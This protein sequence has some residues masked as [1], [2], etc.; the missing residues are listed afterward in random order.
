MIVTEIIVKALSHFPVSLLIIQTPSPGPRTLLWKVWPGDPQKKLA[1]FPLLPFPRRSS[2]SLART[3]WLCFLLLRFFAFCSAILA[4]SFPKNNLI[5]QSMVMKMDT[6]GT[7]WSEDCKWSRYQVVGLA[8]TIGLAR[9]ENSMILDWAGNMQ[10][11][12]IASL[13][14]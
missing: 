10:H 11:Q 1:F 12:L 13:P 3:F 14:K 4:E 8:T 7:A 9:S 5:N 6:L 2:F